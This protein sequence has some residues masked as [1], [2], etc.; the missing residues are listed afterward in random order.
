V[1]DANDASARPTTAYQRA[2]GDICNIRNADLRALERRSRSLAARIGRAR[3]TLAQRNV[4]L[5]DERQVVK[6]SGDALARFQGITVPEFVA[7]DHQRTAA[8]WKR[9][10]N[11]HRSYEHRLDSVQDRSDLL[12][13]IAFLSRSRPTLEQNHE[14]MKTGL[15]RLGGLAC[16]LDRPGPTTSVALPALA[17]RGSR[18]RPSGT[19]TLPP[20]DE[21]LITPTVGPPA[22]S[23]P[24]VMIDARLI[25]TRFAV[26]GISRTAV[27][28]AGGAIVPKGTT[29]RFTVST[30]SIIT[31]TIIHRTRGRRRGNACVA[32]TEHLIRKRRCTATVRD[33]RLLRGIA[34]GPAAIRFG[35]RIRRS[36]LAPRKYTLLIEF[37]DFQGRAGRLRTLTFVV[38][39]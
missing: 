17:S 25:P 1:P 8:L 34:A 35:G 13:A 12:L 33:G 9:I 29:L 21:G 14:A 39:R 30:A 24:P 32:T 23:A 6:R 28:G 22:A 15:L 37:T 5:D 31:L 27:A 2:V 10:V 7:A 20:A 3:S 36:A 11:R 38:T 19:V 16:Q 18:D 4:L 26:S